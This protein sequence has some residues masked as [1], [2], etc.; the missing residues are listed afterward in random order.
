[1]RYLLLIFTFKGFY[2]LGKIRAIEQGLQL[3]KTDLYL[4]KLQGFYFHLKEVLIF[5]RFYI[6]IHNI[7]YWLKQPIIVVYFS[8]VI[9]IV[10]LLLLLVFYIAKKTRKLMK[11]II[12]S[13]DNPILDIVRENKEFEKLKEEKIKE[14]TKELED[15][16]KSIKKKE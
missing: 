10:L 4:T 7:A 6:E 11:K 5:D 14:L 3:D 9:L 16:K 1:M 12:D 13:G 8:L 2:D 15:L